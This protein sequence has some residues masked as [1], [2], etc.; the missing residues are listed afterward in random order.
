[1]AGKCHRNPPSRV[2]AGAS[3]WPPVPA[4][5]WCGEWSGTL[6]PYTVVLDGKSSP[7]FQECKIGGGIGGKVFHGWGEAPPDKVDAVD[8]VDAVDITAAEAIARIDKENKTFSLPITEKTAA[9]LDKI[10]IPTETVKVILPPK[11]EKMVAAV[12][13][14]EL[15]LK[16]Q[17]LLTE[18]DPELRKPSLPRPPI[19]PHSQPVAELPPGNKRK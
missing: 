8:A 9:E 3:A 7:E 10:G 12:S 11:P 17:G 14:T 5:E 13:A 15:A 6:P 4:A 19:H 18:P 1:M 2:Q 16:H